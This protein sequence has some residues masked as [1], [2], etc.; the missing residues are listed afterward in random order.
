MTTITDPE[1]MPSFDSTAVPTH[2]H[3]TQGSAFT[4]AT[5]SSPPVGFPQNE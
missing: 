5:R 4:P 1:A 2:A 3:R